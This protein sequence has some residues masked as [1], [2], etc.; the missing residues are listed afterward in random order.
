[1][2]ALEAKLDKVSEKLSNLKIVHVEVTTVDMHKEEALRHKSQKN[3]Y[4]R[5]TM[6]NWWEVGL[7]WMVSGLW[8]P[9]NSFPCFICVSH[10]IHR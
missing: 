5:T 6:R 3:T 9:V 4:C 8:R 10:A 7:I 2:V 1:M